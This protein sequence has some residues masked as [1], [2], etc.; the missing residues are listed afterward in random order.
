MTKPPTSSTA[1]STALEAYLYGY[2]LITTEVT[3]VVA[4]HYFSG[5]RFAPEAEAELR[6]L[7]QDGFVVHVMRTTA[8]V[9]YLMQSCGQ[10]IIL[11][12]A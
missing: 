4:S 3:R 1:A 7:H 10:L 5:V 9:N 8:W 2:S 6:K 11:A 12:P